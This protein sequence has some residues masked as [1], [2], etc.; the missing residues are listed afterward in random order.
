[1][2][3]LQQGEDGG[4]DNE[5][6]EDETPLNKTNEVLYFWT[7]LMSQQVRKKFRVISS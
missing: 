5:D 3:R 6:Y 7:G 4:R 1:M 2:Q